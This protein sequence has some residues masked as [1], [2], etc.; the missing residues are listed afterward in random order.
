MDETKKNYLLNR[1]HR[2]DK[3]YIQ[4]YIDALH[5]RSEEL[6]I[7]ANRITNIAHRYDELIDELME[8]KGEK[9]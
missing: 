9:E 4:G 5:M 7:E 3:E 2:E 1:L 8:M 6:Y